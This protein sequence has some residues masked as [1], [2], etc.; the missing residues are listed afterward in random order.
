MGFSYGVSFVK[1]DL[2]DD[3]DVF[4]DDGSPLSDDVI[5]DID[6]VLPSLLHE[7]IDRIHYLACEWTEKKT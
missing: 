4:V 1:S 5:M 2:F 3:L 7:P 6:D